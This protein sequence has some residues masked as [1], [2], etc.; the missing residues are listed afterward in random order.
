MISKCKCGKTPWLY[1]DGGHYFVLC[2][3]CGERTTICWGID[4]AIREW[5]AMLKEKGK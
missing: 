5:E 4:D 3:F 1:E 2:R